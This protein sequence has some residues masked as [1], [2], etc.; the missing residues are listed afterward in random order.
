VCVFS[1]SVCGVSFLLIS[2]KLSSGCL[3]RPHHVNQGG[4]QRLPHKSLFT[5]PTLLKSLSGDAE[6]AGTTRYFLTMRANRGLPRV[7]EKKRFF[8]C[9]MFVEC[10]IP[11]PCTLHTLKTPL[12]TIFLHP[13]PP[14]YKN[15][16][17]ET[18]HSSR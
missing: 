11:P 10:L 16:R 3:F 4:V 12:K 9:Q 14:D 17:G 2:F 18:F 6:V 8:F 15:P 7:L 13:P 5:I 1:V